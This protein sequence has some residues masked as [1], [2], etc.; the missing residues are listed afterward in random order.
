MTPPRGL[1]ALA[2]VRILVVED[3]P[4][5]SMLI[6][7]LLLD[8][9]CMVVGPA[10]TVAQALAL[11]GQ[12]V[13]A[14]LLDVNLGAEHVYPVADALAAADVPFA[15]VTGYGR[16]GLVG[17]HCDRPTIHKPFAPASFGREVASALL[18]AGRR[19]AAS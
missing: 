5:V 11:V 6:E 1:E 4:L 14:A 9:G 3:E 8:L 7:D 16:H 10:S 18:P 12:D 17:A 13:D 19:R 15:F 2:G